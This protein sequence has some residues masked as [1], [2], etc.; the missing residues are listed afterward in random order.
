MPR[1][2]RGL[3][4]GQIYH[5]INRGNGRQD[6]FHADGDYRAFAELMEEAGTRYP[7]KLLAWCLMPNHF[8]LLISLEQADDLSKWMQWLMTSHV[9]R[10]HRFHRS[11]GHIWQ[12]RYKSFIVQKDKHLL[13]VI[14]YI[15]ANPV[16][17]ALV[18]S[19]REWQWSSH[20]GRA[21]MVKPITDAPAI[22]LPVEWTKYVDHPMIDM[23][24]EKIRRCLK[25]QAP[26]GEPNWQMRIC[27]DLGLE[28]T[29]KPMG[30]PR[31]W[32]QEK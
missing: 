3:A 24:L 6:V 32:G 5:I 26:Y 8:H 16:R 21:G 20:Q 10:Y 18:A 30:R 27:R 2:A 7:V 19:A 4:D 13:T 25:R 17:A 22:P 1:V 14:R 9:R 15:E 28:S 31:K 23:E 29:I 12:G 11:S